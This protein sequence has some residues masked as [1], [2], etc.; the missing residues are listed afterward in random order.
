MSDYEPSLA[1]IDAALESW[2][3]DSEMGWK[4]NPDFA[5]RAFWRQ[6]MRAALIAA[7]RVRIIL[8]TAMACVETAGRIELAPLGAS[9]DE[10]E[11]IVMPTQDVATIGPGD[12]HLQT[13]SPYCRPCAEWP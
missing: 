8:P 3:P 9:I 1:E 10:P 5:N 11:L 12:E 2:F 7:N 13:K 6:T 4:G